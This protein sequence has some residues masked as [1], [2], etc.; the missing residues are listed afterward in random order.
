MRVNIDPSGL[1]SLQK[2]HLAIALVRPAP[3]SG[4]RSALAFALP[5][6]NIIGSTF[7][8]S[9]AP[10]IRCLAAVGTFA[11]MALLVPGLSSDPI[12]RSDID[13]AG[14]G[15]VFA[16][17]A[18]GIA[19]LEPPVPGTLLMENGSEGQI[20]NLTMG[21]AEA[22]S[23][24][25]SNSEVEAP[26]LVTTVECGFRWAIE[27]PGQAYLF[28]IS[29]DV[30]AGTIIPPAFYVPP[31]PVKATTA[32]MVTTTRAL[33]VDPSDDKLTVTYKAATNTFVKS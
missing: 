31:P 14:V 18:I 23:N 30:P 7:T 3:S 19:P 13:L 1:S 11:D 8:I 5:A 12:D 6:S 10:R 25:A 9:V 15:C 20:N 21:L 28:L 22:F 17:N 32:R 29:D 16:A 24:S 33:L 27:P 2:K 26:T 4:I